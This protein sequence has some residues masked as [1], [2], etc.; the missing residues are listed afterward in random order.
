MRGRENSDA[1]WRGG[2]GR[3][4]LEACFF[5]LLSPKECLERLEWYWEG[6]EACCVV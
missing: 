3:W 1:E 4:F 2:R 6:V 5:F